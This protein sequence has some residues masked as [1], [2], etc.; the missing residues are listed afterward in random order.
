MSR[1]SRRALIGGVGATL[2]ASARAE[3]APTLVR[4]ANGGAGVPISPYIYGSSEIGTLDGRA[5]SAV[6]DRAAGVTARRFGGNLATSYDWVTNASNAGKD[7][8]QANGDFF[9]D[10]LGLS[11]PERRQPGAA[12][13]R[14]HENSLAMGAISLVTLPLVGFV[15]GDGAGPV[16]PGERAPS[17]R[18]VPVRW[19]GST[20]ADTPVDPRVANIPHL[21][22]RLQA[23]FGPASASTGIRGY[24]LDN[25]PDLW[26]T[27]HPRIVTAPVR[28]ADLLARSIMAARVIKRIDPDAW[29][30][31]PA[32]WGATGMASLQD[33]PDWPAYRRHGSFLAAYL[34]AF[35]RES[36]RDGHRLLDA[37]DVHWYP[38]S[39]RGPLYRT[40]DPALAG[41]LLD[42]PRSLSEPGFREA[43][44]VSRALPV[45]DTGGLSLPLLPSL[46]R[47]VDAN[48]PGTRI[49]I[50][51]YNYGGAGQ[52]ASGLALADA[53]TR[54]ARPTTLAAMHWGGLDGWLG[55]AYRLYRNYDGR[56][57]SL[58][59]TG[60]DVAVS[61]PDL[62]SARAAVS[63]PGRLHVVLVNRSE[64][65]QPVDLILD[66]PILS[67][68]MARY[69][70]DAAHPR[71]AALGPEEPSDRGRIRLVLPARSAQHCVLRSAA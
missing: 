4:V 49:A 8:R 69:G 16:G 65:A 55:E 41:P 48:F 61:R 40:E 5:P 20:A 22:A 27:Q 62:L 51:E 63:G 18:F 29:V 70:F 71:V 46:E 42:A 9:A 45:A 26:A 39:D 43:S 24:I 6:L 36:E 64:R 13:V 56:G 53:L 35:R 59:G 60:F 58:P 28:I 50:T 11:E 14:M 33:A 25:E 10:H 57:A 1:L 52:L 30:I 31:G 34:D 15:A 2:W 3:D 47:L 37:L 67:P 7:Y 32:S 19:S 38:F 44:W 54:L 68:R 66:V 21:L 12:I 23:R 17:K